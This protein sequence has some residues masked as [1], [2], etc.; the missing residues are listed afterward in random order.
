MTNRH[1]ELNPQAFKVFGPKLIAMRGNF[2]DEALESRFLTEETGG[3]PLRRDISIHLPDTMKVEA[4][5][6]RNKLLAWRFHARNSVGIDATRLVAGISPRG[7]QTALPLLSLVDDHAL[8]ERIADHLV[9]VE[10]RAGAKRATSPHVTMVGVLHRAFQAS[11]SPHIKLA[12]AT[13][14][15]NQR[16]IER[17][18]H[19]VTPKTA[20]YI[21]RSELGLQTRKSNGVYVISQSEKHAVAELA[22][23]YGQIEELSKVR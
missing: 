20:G 19:P 11:Q 6:L 13:H 9:T 4:Q 8:R 16:A 15:F 12:D 21:V 3:R 1:R 18:E 7:N 2:A 22:K 5:E 17:G 10:A 14:S 23:R